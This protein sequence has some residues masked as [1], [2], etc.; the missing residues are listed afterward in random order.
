MFSKKE[1]LWSC[2]AVIDD[3][4]ESDWYKRYKPKWYGVLK[5]GVRFN[6]NLT[7]GSYNVKNNILTIIIRGSNELGDWF[8]SQGNF[9][10]HLTDWR[11]EKIPLTTKIETK[12]K[13]AIGWKRAWKDIK[14]FVFGLIDQHKPKKIQFITHSRGGPI[15][16]IGAENVAFKYPDVKVK[17][18]YFSSPTAGNKYFAQAHD[19]KVEGIMIYINGDVVC[20]VP[21]GFLGFQQISNVKGFWSWGW[22][23][24]VYPHLPTTLLKTLEKKY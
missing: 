19:A 3:Y 21:P 10:F 20:A 24:I 9:N 7:Q 22:P 14:P 5:D 12:A 2:K 4:K 17:G 8:G 13:V 6:W 11:T 1:L 16:Q 23:P 15:G 18:I